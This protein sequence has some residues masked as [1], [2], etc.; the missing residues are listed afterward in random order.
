VYFLRAKISLTAALPYLLGGFAGGLLGGK[1]YGKVSTVWL[2]W[3]F[4][5]F[6]FYAG[7]NYLL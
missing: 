3:V 5:A 1:L 2:K 7:V 6:L 4:A